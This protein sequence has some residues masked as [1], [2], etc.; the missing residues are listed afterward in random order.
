[1]YATWPVGTSLT[2]AVSVQEILSWICS[3]L[4]SLPAEIEVLRFPVR[5]YFS[6]STELSDGHQHQVVAALSHMYPSLRELEMGYHNNPHWE[7]N[8]TL[9]KRKGVNSYIQ[10]HA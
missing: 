2:G 4:V 10:V 1:M 6:Q 5:S 7:R 3:G 9:W 8:G